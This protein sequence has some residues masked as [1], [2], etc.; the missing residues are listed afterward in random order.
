LKLTRKNSTSAA[1]ARRSALWTLALTSS[2]WTSTALGQ[3]SP[4]RGGP[5]PPSAFGRAGL[6]RLGFG[7]CADQDDPQ[8]IWTA[9]N[10][11][12]PELFLF[13]GDNVYGDTLDMSVLKAKYAKLGDKPGFQ[14]LRRQS[15][16]AATWDDHDYGKNDAGREYPMKVAS[17][18]IFLDFF[19]EPKS[20]ARRQREG[21]YTSY[22]LGP[23]D[24]RVQVI[25]LDA[26]TF[27]SPLASR[28]VSAELEQRHVGGYRPIDR[29]DA[30]ML[31]A[32]QW[33]WLEKQLKQP[34]RLRVF[35]MSTQ[36]LVEFNGFEA[37]ANMPRERGRLIKLLRRTKAEGAVF[38]SGDTHWAE[39]SMVE[40][41]GMYPLFDLTSS[42]LTQVWKGVGPN[43]HRILDSYLGANFGT[44]EIDWDQPDPSLTLS[45]RDVEGQV[46]VSHT[47]ALS[48]LTFKGGLKVAAERRFEG[49]WDTSYGRLTLRRD[50]RKLVG[51]YGK[52]A[53]LE[54]RIKK[55]QLHG[56]WSESDG[57]KSGRVRFHLSR[58][59][60]H[61]QGAWGLSTQNG[62]PF[63]WT[64]TRLP[65]TP[66]P[67]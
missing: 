32:A 23:P 30:T 12:R 20:T 6:T 34:A 57:A 27:R 22:L 29:A 17:K 18:Q 24:R 7:S 67:P 46:R 8:P 52:G 50:G 16:L 2:A 55:G 4:G 10:R 56:I 42:G 21:L 43:T 48:L 51:S 13:L 37:W 9:V 28:K 36:F 38:L 14:T 25:V 44:L 49:S 60:R 65:P 35:A 5:P 53:R 11:W 61:L 40:Q 45:V 66:D 58:D 19:R 41:A 39:L 54:G 31:G 1:R 26:R 62:L 33:R 59:G 3:E 64:G 15:Y 47:V 63:S